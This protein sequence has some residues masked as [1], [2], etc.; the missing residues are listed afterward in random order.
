MW[1]SCQVPIMNT[2]NEERVQLEALKEDIE[3]V[4]RVF[5]KTLLLLILQFF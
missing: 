5:L 3:T 2:E 4:A 1:K